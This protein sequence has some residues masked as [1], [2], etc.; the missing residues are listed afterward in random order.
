MVKG[1]V[2]IVAASGKEAGLRQGLVFYLGALTGVKVTERERGLRGYGKRCLLEFEVE[3]ELK[4]VKAWAGGI[5]AS[6]SDD[7]IY[8]KFE[9]DGKLVQFYFELFYFDRYAEFING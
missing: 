1:S 9:E 2:E 6:V 5:K 3:G 7:C 4:Q 8:W